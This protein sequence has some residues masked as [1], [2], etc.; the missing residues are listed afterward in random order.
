M[1]SI[2]ADLTSV[3]AVIFYVSK[4]NFLPWRQADKTFRWDYDYVEV[5]DS[6]SVSGLKNINTKLG[7]ELDDWAVGS[8]SSISS[9]TPSP[10]EDHHSGWDEDTLASSSESEFE[11]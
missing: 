9:G 5:G 4:S 10:T 1:R 11:V 2:K 3:S 8:S 6:D 7:Y